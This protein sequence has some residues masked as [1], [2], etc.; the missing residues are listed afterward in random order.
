MKME[1][2]GSLVVTVTVPSYV[3]TAAGMN[4]TS[5]DTESPAASEVTDGWLSRMNP[6]PAIVIGGS[7]IVAVPVLVMV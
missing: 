5:N 3:P 4:S 7:F 1:F 6:V 2:A